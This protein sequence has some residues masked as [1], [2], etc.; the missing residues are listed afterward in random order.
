[1]TKS[2]AASTIG[3]DIRVS[4]RKQGRDVLTMTARELKDLSEERVSEL[5]GELYAHSI[6]GVA[7]RI[8][9]PIAAARAAKREAI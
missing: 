5:R 7:A 8:T 3:L 1:M 2:E 9:T 4:A 6:K